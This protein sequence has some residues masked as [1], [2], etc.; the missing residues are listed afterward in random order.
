MTRS[1][2]PSSP[3]EAREYAR[4]GRLRGNTSGM[5]PGHVQANLLIL[6]AKY[7][8][9]FRRLCARNP[10]SCP[11]LAESRATG[12]KGFPAGVADGAD[13]TTDIPG[14]KVY[15]DGKFVEEVD[16]VVNYWGEDSVAFLIG[17]SFTFEDA[18]QDAGLGVRHIDEDRNV[19]MYRTSVPLMPSGV[20]SGNTVVS[21]RPYPP[22]QVERVRTIT[23][24]YVR[25][26]GE[27]IA[28]GWDAIEKLGIN[29]INKP[30]YGDAPIIR[31]GEV[32]VFWAC[33]VTPQLVVIN[34]HIE[35]VVIGHAPG[36]MLCLD[37]R[38][39]DI[40]DE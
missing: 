32:P 28:W 11:L 18:L 5:C 40:Q 7:A 25:T 17:C 33:G 3:T 34:S 19:P 15:R 9:D 4:S 10:V 31:D 16:D 20:F 38:I 24:P 35:G 12:D 23:R 1:L 8:A 36:K 39:E 37:W 22:E 13:I 14:Y 2:S 30:E 29:D 6:P 21:M 27:P 26:H